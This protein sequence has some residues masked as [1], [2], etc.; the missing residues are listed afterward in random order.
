MVPLGKREPGVYLVEAVNDN[1]R[2]YTVVVV[3]NLALVEKSSPNGE[4][5]FYAVNRATG[6]PQP[7]TKVSVLKARN[8]VV[9]GTTN[10][11]GIFRA[12]IKKENK[13]EEEA[14]VEAEPDPM[15]EVDNNDFLVLASRRED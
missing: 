7:D 8:S 5:L 3:T 4:L 2:A 15:A 9:T 14:E 1:L 13:E 10:A 11:E 6:E 12:R